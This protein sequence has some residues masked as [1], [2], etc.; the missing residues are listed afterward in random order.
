MTPL[1][2]MEQF[3]ADIAAAFDD[4]PKPLDGARLTGGL[5]VNRQ[6]IVDG[7]AVG[8]ELDIKPPSDAD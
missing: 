5:M 3:K 7:A 6:G 2:P 8:I 4:E 1:S